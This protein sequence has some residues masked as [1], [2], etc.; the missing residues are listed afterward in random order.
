MTERLL[1]TIDAMAKAMGAQRA[2]DIAG[3]HRRHFD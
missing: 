3:R 1:W 2:G